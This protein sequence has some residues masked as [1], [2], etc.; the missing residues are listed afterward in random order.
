MITALAKKYAK[1]KNMKHNYKV[2][3]I[4][5]VMLLILS[6]VAVL[7]AGAITVGN[8]DPALSIVSTLDSGTY[9]GVQSVILK[10]TDGAEI[11]YT[12]DR[13]IPTKETGTRYEGALSIGSE[14]TNT[15]TYLTAVAEKDGLYS[16]V[17]RWTY[18][19][20]PP[21]R[22]LITS[23]SSVKV[24][25][26]VPYNGNA[27]APFKLYHTGEN[28]TAEQFVAQVTSNTVGDGQNS[29]SY[30]NND[31][32]TTYV[33]VDLGDVYTINK[34]DWQ[35][36]A[37]FNT[38]TDGV[39]NIR[40][41]VSEDGD[42]WT[43]VYYNPEA[44]EMERSKFGVWN[45]CKY[46]EITF[47]PTPARYV[48]VTTGYANEEIF[49]SMLNIYEGSFV[50]TDM[51]D[52]SG[53]NILEGQGGW[54]TLENH[55]TLNL[56]GGDSPVYV[57]S[58]VVT[59]LPT[60]YAKIVD[61]TIGDG[62]ESYYY[63]NVP[64][65]QGTT[66][67][68][69]ELNKEYTLDRF[70]VQRG[71]YENDLG[72]ENFKM[73]GSLNGEDWF[74][75]YYEPET[76]VN[77]K[78]EQGIWN[79]CYFASVSIDPTTVRYIRISQGQ[80]GAMTSLSELR[81]YAASTSKFQE[82]VVPDSYF[83]EYLDP[84]EIAGK[85]ML[86]GH[87][88]YVTLQNYALLN[89][90]SG[91]FPVYVQS[92]ATVQ[93]TQFYDKLV[94]GIIG[95]GHESYYYKNVPAEQGTTYVFFDMQQPVTIDKFDAQAGAYLNDH[96]I[97]NL[98][99]EGSL[100]GEE[101]YTVYHEPGETLN[102]DWEQGPWNQCNFA[103]VNITPVPV[104]YVRVSMGQPDETVG[105]SEF[106]LYAAAEQIPV[107][108]EQKIAVA[109]DESLPLAD[110]EAW[111]AE[112]YP[113]YEFLLS[114]TAKQTFP[115]VW[116]REFDERDYRFGGVFTFYGTP[117]I[118]GATLLT[119]LYNTGI[120]L[121]VTLPVTGVNT[122][123]LEEAIARAE[124]LTASDYSDATWSHMQTSLAAARAV[125]ASDHLTL[126]AVNDATFALERDINALL[127][128]GDTAALSARITELS[129][130]RDDTYSKITFEALTAALE[131]A[132]T[133]LGQSRPS[134]K[135]CDDALAA[136]NEAHAALVD[137]SALAESITA[138]ESS[139]EAAETYTKSSY[140]AYV[141]VLT[142]AKAA[143]E[144]GR[145]AEEVEKAKADLDNAVKALEKAGDRSGLQTLLETAKAISESLYTPASFRDLASAIAAAEELLSAEELSVSDAEAAEAAIKAAMEA[146]VKVG[147]KTELNALIETYGTESQF[148]PTSWSEFKT[149]LD[150]AKLVAADAEAS[151]E[152]VNTAVAELKAAAE[153]LV[154][155]GDKTE[156]TALL[157][158][159]RE[160]ASKYTS[161]S[162]NAYLL[163]IENAQLVMADPEASEED[164]QAALDALKAAV[165]G[166]VTV[167]DGT[168]A[169]TDAADTADTSTEKGGC[170][171]VLSGAAVILAV[172]GLFALA[173]RR[174]EN[175]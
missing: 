139:V 132:N 143:L 24:V 175:D 86:Q 89:L 13:T 141:A 162:Y 80:A 64:A 90:G 85:N 49:L 58:G 52:Y 161:A 11:Y 154:K 44:E 174:K 43:E 88:N 32:A 165:S 26:Y 34:L 7:P 14:E 50:Y 12:T 23:T 40:I 99:I 107:L 108:T 59:D 133:L 57:Q 79:T 116:A 101:W 113:S 160:D 117:D 145:T 87:G 140:D 62:H 81:L 29:Y 56:G 68:K 98:K 110:L 82:V 60:F 173:V 39:Y 158:Q 83:E 3:I 119:D 134:Q 147:D 10:A 61:G 70:E 171:S 6:V 111:I 155:V 19:V 148:S 168:D 74:V 163:A 118:S 151:E 33:E 65:E 152:A 129:A 55:G 84:A 20:N 37:Y 167:S 54:V 53:K 97:F 30:F 94:D 47:A 9:D 72:P 138:A 22:N 100:D 103:R 126:L 8:Q 77:N 137:V 16:R 121:E 27:D 2:R 73:E 35:R 125:L 146:L 150:A 51:T 96:G 127:A 122:R 38:A 128:A 123:F 21:T 66:Y 156:L 115:L 63:M 41:Q 159:P 130:I 102:T 144:N 166:L 91:D 112:Q 42:K 25:D 106:R 71:V 149:V 135:D 131:S 142:A 31:S 69:I 78:S 105:F 172:M 124:A 36:T 75:M 170:G 95:D 67:V 15:I 136:L 5:V 46:A 164:V 169:G 157:E 153:K 28:V 109:F 114:D 1:E 120:V 18:T 45:D 76:M 92:G 104:R 4:T 17:Y 48:R 93:L